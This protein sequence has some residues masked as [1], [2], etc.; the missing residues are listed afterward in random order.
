MEIAAVATTGWQL[1]ESRQHYFERF[2]PVDEESEDSKDLVD[3]D[4]RSVVSE[5]LGD[6]LESLESPLSSSGSQEVCFPCFLDL[7]FF[8]LNFLRLHLL[9]NCPRAL[10]DVAHWGYLLNGVHCL[11]CGPGR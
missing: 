1:A 5:S 6:E 11:G 10:S 9:P 3:S 2:G 4:A 7:D 8:L